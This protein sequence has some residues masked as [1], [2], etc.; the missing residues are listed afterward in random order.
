MSALKILEDNAIVSGQAIQTIRAKIAH[1]KA[2]SAHAR[3]ALLAYVNQVFD[4]ED[5]AN[6]MLE[7][8]ERI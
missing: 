7:S 3:E 2:Q 1:R 6:D 4:A 5:A 8:G